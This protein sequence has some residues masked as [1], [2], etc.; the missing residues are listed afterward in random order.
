[1]VWIIASCFQLWVD[2]PVGVLITQILAHLTDLQYFL[3]RR[4]HLPNALALPLDEFSHV[5]NVIFCTCQ[6]FLSIG[7]NLCHSPVSVVLILMFATS[8]EYSLVSPYLCFFNN[9]VKIVDRQFALDGE[10][11]IIPH[12]RVLEYYS[13]VFWVTNNFHF[14]VYA[15]ENIISF[16]S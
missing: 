16:K 7:E 8:R 2:I 3:F 13:N 15:S 14:C 10:R 12:R 4:I 6:H 1:M 11:E 9:S 5:N